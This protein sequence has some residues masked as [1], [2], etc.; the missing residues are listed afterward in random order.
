M[1]LFPRLTL[2]EEESADGASTDPLGLYATADLLAVRLAPGVRERQQRPR[3]LTIMAVSAAVCEGFAEDRIAK[4][5]VSPAWQVF[6]WYVV[7]GLVRRIGGDEGRLS[8][9]PGSQKV[10][11]AVG[12]QGRVSARG[13]LKAPSVFGFH[14][15]YRTLARELRI[16]HETGIDEAGARL[17]R[18][19]EQEQQI[20]SGWRK[21]FKDAIDAGLEKGCTGRESGWRGFELI[22]KHLAHDR[23][24]R[25]E[26][27]TLTALLQSECDGFRGDLFRF[28]ISDEARGIWPP[29]DGR[30]ESRVHEH[31]A[32]SASSELRRLL[33]AIRRF[34]QFS[35]VLTDAFEECRYEMSRAQRALTA[36]DF[37]RLDAVIEGARHTEEYL[38]QAQESLEPLGC[39][40]RLSR[41][42]DLQDYSNDPSKWSEALLAI[43]DR[44]QK[45][46]PPHGKAAWVI[47]YENGEYR[48]R[49][50]YRIDTF[51]ARPG[52]YVH[53]YRA[54][55]LY[56]FARD[57]QLV[58]QH[59]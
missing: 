20:A 14:G 38:Q 41:F 25:K 22:E 54:R 24:G 55:P 57:L 17:L 48:L 33:E 26:G 47:R 35:R 49:P 21:L 42:E 51:E 58:A 36:K 13:Y 53:Q 7:E 12:E 56:S 29:G 27:E 31:L 23:P 40:A 18:L 39:A 9:L 11:F 45:E 10:R 8:G 6:E 30:D 4:D 59:G 44:V 15:V 46:K 28:L 2:P 32:K 37:A 43:H 52:T 50:P 16:V 34:E 19:W 3:F 1:S 5:G